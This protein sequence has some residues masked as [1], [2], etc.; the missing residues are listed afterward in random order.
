[1]LMEGL[2]ALLALI[3]K[4][5]PGEIVL[6]EYRPS[7]IPEFLTKLLVEYGRKKGVP[8]VI[9]DNFDTL[10]VIQ[11]HL[12]FWGIDEDFRDVLVVKSGGRMMVGNVVAEV[13]FSSEPLVYIKKYEK[14]FKEAVSGVENSI[15]IVLGL[16]R[17]FAFI[18]SPREYYLFITG[19]QNMLG[20]RR[21]KAFYLIN[22]K[23]ASTLDFNPLPE[24]EYIASTVVRITPTPTSARTVFVKT[25]IREF[26][27]S[28]FE[29]TLEVVLDAFR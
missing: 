17:L 22:E 15:N 14:T 1:M 21:R 10:H 16:E 29:I 13:E 6:I 23:I 8:V 2:N 9:D 3:E 24:L 26:L 25:P 27:G 20:N 12:K 7:Y 19:L 4:V 18:N 5:N 11:K 28:E